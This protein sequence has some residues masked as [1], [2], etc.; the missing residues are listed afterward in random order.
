MVELRRLDVS[1]VNEVDVNELVERYVK[2]YADDRDIQVRSKF[3]TVSR[4]KLRVAGGA[5][6]PGAR[7]PGSPRPAA[8]VSTR[9]PVPVSLLSSDASPAMARARQILVKRL[10]GG[11]R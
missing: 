8:P 10:G 1:D 3:A 11:V 6:Q 2:E 9:A 7:P 5:V 4:E